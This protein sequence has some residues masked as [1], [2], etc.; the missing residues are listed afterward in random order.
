MTK[1]ITGLFPSAWPR[2]PSSTRSRSRTRRGSRTSSCSRRLPCSRWTPR[3]GSG[4]P[5]SPIPDLD[6]E[7]KNHTKDISENRG[8]KLPTAHFP[9]SG[10]VL[11]TLQKFASCAIFRPLLRVFTASCDLQALKSIYYTFSD[12]FWG[13]WFSFLTPLCAFLRIFKQVSCKNFETG[14]VATLNV[15]SEFLPSSPPS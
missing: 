8:V 13:G 15:Q 12:S 4:R 11:H 9:T 2:C 1:K 3:A 10:L 14:P 7:K 6:K 5:A